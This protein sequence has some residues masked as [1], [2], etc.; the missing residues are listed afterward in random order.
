MTS[1]KR[2]DLSSLD[3]LTTVERASRWDELALSYQNRH[4]TKDGDRLSALSGLARRFQ[5][6]ALGTYVAGLWCNFILSMLLWEV[7]KGRRA[8]EY[9]A[10]SWAWASC[11]GRL[12]RNDTI[13]H[14]SKF[15]AV[16]EEVSCEPATG[17]LYGAIMPLSG[18]ITLCSPT[19]E[20]AVVRSVLNGH[21]MIQLTPEVQA[22]L[23]SDVHLTDSQIGG[24]V[25]CMFLRG[26][27]AG[28]SG[29]YVEALVLNVSKNLVDYE[30]LGVA[31]IRKHSFDEDK[32]LRENLP[33]VL[34][35]IKII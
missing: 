19:M 35:T 14:N 17:D 16:L 24:T 9:V 30:R 23:V 18:F 20:G 34:E 29:R 22:F 21:P 3:R 26:L 33:L 27:E 4:I 28:P 10:P 13:E 1:R 11:Q 8:S 6:D 15:K 25:K 7:K 2:Y 32:S 5:C 31:H 12:I